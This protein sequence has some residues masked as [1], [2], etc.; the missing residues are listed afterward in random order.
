M[1]RL[2]RILA[3]ATAVVALAML[4][5]RAY[6]GFDDADSSATELTL[7]TA[8]ATTAATSGGTHAAL[9]GATT[10]PP[11]AVRVVDAAHLRRTFPALQRI[12]V[13][14]DGLAAGDARALRG[15]AI[16]WQR[17]T[18][19]APAGPEL[20]DVAAPRRLT[21]GERLTVQG[22]LRLPPAAG[23]FTISLEGPDGVKQAI[24]LRAAADGHALFA[25]TSATPAI[26][27]GAF[28]WRLRVAPQ[29]EPLVLGVWVTRPDRP[30]VLILQ[31]SPTVEAGR[32]QR[33]LAETGGA[34][35][36]RTRVSA[37]HMRFTTANGAP[38]DFA[39]LDAATLRQL[40]I[41]VAGEPA[42]VELGADE[43]DALET[44]IAEHGL[45]LL[46]LGGEATSQPD[47]RFSPWVV[48]SETPA[49]A[50]DGARL[51]RLRL[52]DGREFAEPIPVP[53][54]ELASPPP[55]R[56][57]VRD[58]QDRTYGATVARGR[59]WI[60][61]TLVTDTWRWLQGGHPEMYASYWSGLLSAISRP[62]ATTGRWSFEAGSRP[63]FPGEPVRLAWIGAP[64][65]PLPVAE[66]NPPAGSPATPVPLS[67]ARDRRD[68]ARAEAIYFP[69]SPGWHEVAVR[70]V[71]PT[72]AFHVHSPTALP[73]VRTERRRNATA[74]L[75]GAGAGGPIN[76]TPA[77]SGGS[78][79][80]PPLVV[81]AA[82]FALFVASASALWWEQRGAGARTVG[83]GLPRD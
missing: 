62:A 37:E 45:G 20:I 61:R 23:A 39:R 15:L 30:R 3:T 27:P 28:E 57:L 47:P 17:P 60:A 5:W 26:A 48:R 56:W 69:A 50:G 12:Q 10:A 66:V 49:A 74:L 77:G 40:D 58:P 51:A 9:P 65:A 46:V 31:A 18:S 72:F 21:V 79:G 54:L 29:G 70:P 53:P 2:I 6:Q 24:D 64:E 78:A 33:W 25:L 59:G 34:V 41:V 83:A 52:S 13:K 55:G 76:P 68:P 42:L 44:A 32:L 67:L 4:G 11:D 73:G 81:S 19:P 1:R 7:W 80:V 8:G 71:G 63:V 82:W 75:A 43:R 14:D 36:L 38:S 16:T 35:S 22:R